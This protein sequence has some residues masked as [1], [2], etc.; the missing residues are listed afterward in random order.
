MEDY[1]TLTYHVKRTSHVQTIDQSLITQERTQKLDL[2]MH[3]LSNLTQSLVVCGPDG[4]GKTTLIKV[5]QERKHNSWL[6]CLVHGHTDLSFEKI[7]EQLAEVMSQDKPRMDLSLPIAFEHYESENKK[8]IL[9]IDDAGNLVPGLIT[10]LIQYAAANPVLRLVLVLTHDDLYLKNRTDRAIEDCHFVEIPPLSEK[11]CGDFLQHLAAKP[12]AQ[13]PFNSISDALIEKIYRETHGIPGKIIAELPDL[14]SSKSGPNPTMILV[15]AVAALVIIV[16]GVQW[17]S[18]SNRADVENQQAAGAVRKLA[19]NEPALPQAKSSLTL[20]SQPLLLSEQFGQEN[21]V[22]FFQ[23]QQQDNKALI[24]QPNIND[25][26]KNQPEE[27]KVIIPNNHSSETV[28]AASIAPQSEKPVGTEQPQSKQI[29]NDLASEEETPNAIVMVEDGA[30]WATSQPPDNFTLQV[31]VLTREQAVK[32][33]I[34]RYQ[35]LDQT[36]TYIKSVSPNGREK[37]LLFYGSFASASAANRAKQ[38]L[39]SEFRQ[40]ILRQFNS[41]KK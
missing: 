36:L 20:K 4:I 27:G 21:N 22:E 39:P 34:K 14:A 32:D 11:Q 26:K 6:Y 13:I 2:L 7:L 28:N 1:D 29:E 10:S 3:L 23:G 37:F 12:T 16:L 5:L 35:T 8:I 25:V 33:M 40:S 24:K 19:T 38:S 41:I 31:M 18:G 30:A 15:S 17:L 9:I